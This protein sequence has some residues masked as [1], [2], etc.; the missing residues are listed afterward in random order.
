MRQCYVC[1]F[2]NSLAL[3]NPADQVQIRSGC[4]TWVHSRMSGKELKILVSHNVKDKS[5]SG[6]W[7]DHVDKGPLQ[8]RLQGR[9]TVLGGYVWYP[10]VSFDKLNSKSLN[11]MER[12]HHL[13]PR[14]FWR[15]ASLRRTGLRI[16]QEAAL[17]SPP[18]KS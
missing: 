15:E 2:A 8:A 18:L 1:I 9:L 16:R 6:L 7:G 4:A 3:F 5:Y 11:E 10:M 12:Y 14:T 13:F 17:G